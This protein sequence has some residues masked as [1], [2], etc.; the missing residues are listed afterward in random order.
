MK[1]EDL[2]CVDEFNGTPLAVAFSRGGTDVAVML[3]EAGADLILTNVFKRDLL[4]ATI[5]SG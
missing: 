1:L 2:N 3:Q 5:L 4:C